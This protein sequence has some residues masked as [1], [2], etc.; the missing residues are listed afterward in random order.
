MQIDEFAI[1][2]LTNIAFRGFFTRVIDVLSAEKVELEGTR[3][4]AF[5]EAQQAYDSAIELISAPKQSLKAFDSDCDFTWNYLDRQAKLSDDHYEEAR[6]IA[7]AQVNEAMVGPNPTKLTY[8]KEYPTISAALERLEALP[9]ETLVLAKVDEIVDHLRK[10]YDAF[11]KAQS[12]ETARRAAR[13]NGLAA[14]CR[15]ALNAAWDAYKPVLEISADTN[16]KAKKAISLINEIVE[17]Y[18][19]VIARKTATIAPKK[20]EE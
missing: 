14:K 9:R 6:R 2:K 12:D 16:E 13:E 3:A 4:T 19:Q 8:T 18:R 1:T 5:L 15:A 10:T 7:A 20:P 17:E 11:M